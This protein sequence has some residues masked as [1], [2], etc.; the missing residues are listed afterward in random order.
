VI[1]IHN[2]VLLS[3]KKELNYV[4]CR[5]MDGTGDYH[6]KQNKLGSEGHVF[7]HLQNLDLS[8]YAYIMYA[9]IYMDI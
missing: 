5:K 8:I 7:S 2:G 6:V 1:Y 4:I 9:C 3:H